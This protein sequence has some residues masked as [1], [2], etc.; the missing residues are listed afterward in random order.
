MP[1]IAPL[2][3]GD[4]ESGSAIRELVVAGVEIVLEG[5]E[6]GAD[7][8]G[9]IVTMVALS[10][11]GVSI[12]PVMGKCPAALKNISLVVVIESQPCF[13]C[14]PGVDGNGP[15]NTICATHEGQRSST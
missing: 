4:E 10:G 2:D 12:S 1:A 8:D 7:G 14:L 9:V 6:N 5:M 15:H 11:T 3:K 13:C